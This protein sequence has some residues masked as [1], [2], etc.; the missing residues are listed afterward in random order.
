M[1]DTSFGTRKRNNRCRNKVCACTGECLID[2]G[3]GDFAPRNA[4][5]FK[6]PKT[7]DDLIPRRE[8][9]ARQMLDRLTDMMVEDILEMSDEEITAELIEDGINP[10]KEAKR[11]RKV[12]GQAIKKVKPRPRE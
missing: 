12:I 5:G 8:L 3:T 4:L 9:T 7:V 1:T 2:D 6:I 11:I 10:E